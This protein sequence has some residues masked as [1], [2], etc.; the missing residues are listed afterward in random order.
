MLLESMARQDNLAAERGNGEWQA[1]W[2]CKTNFLAP[3]G[4]VTECTDRG[5]YW[6]Q[7]T[8]L[9]DPCYRVEGWCDGKGFGP[10]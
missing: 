6:W 7:V 8:S 3:N 9:S 1:E 2:W 4:P 5:G 10:D